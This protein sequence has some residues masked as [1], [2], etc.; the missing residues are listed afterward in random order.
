MIDTFTLYIIYRKS[1]CDYV[2]RKH[3]GISRVAL[4]YYENYYRANY[5][6]V[7]IGWK[8][9]MPKSKRNIS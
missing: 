8:E 4:D 5:D 9:D 3:E 1:H 6:L 7:N 2:R